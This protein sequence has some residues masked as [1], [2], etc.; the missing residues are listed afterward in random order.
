MEDNM[1]DECKENPCE[2]IRLF[3]TK[4]TKGLARIKVPSEDESLSTVRTV[5]LQKNV[6]RRDLIQVVTEF[7]PHHAFYF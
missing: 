5:S 1:S 7:L 2:D 4:V 6:L 3:L